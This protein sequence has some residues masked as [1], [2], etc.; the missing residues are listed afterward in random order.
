MRNTT[1]KR[2]KKKQSFKTHLTKRKELRCNCIREW[3]KNY[4]NNILTLSEQK[5]RK[6]DLY[7]IVKN[8]A[9]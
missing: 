7:D 4:D 3:L 9:Y 8:I 5:L 1:R 2:E 6:Q